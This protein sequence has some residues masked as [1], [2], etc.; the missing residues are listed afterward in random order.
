MQLYNS[1]DYVVIVTSTESLKK[2]QNL[3]LNSNK[4]LVACIVPGIEIGQFQGHDSYDFYS[5]DEQQDFSQEYISQHAV[6]FV[7]EIIDPV[8]RTISL[9]KKTKKHILS[10]KNMYA[11][12]AHILVALII[13]LEHLAQ[14]NP[15]SEFIFFGL[16]IPFEFPER[17][18]IRKLFY[19]DDF[20][21]PI[22]FSFFKGRNIRY[23]SIQVRPWILVKFLMVFRS[24]LLTIYKFLVISIRWLKEYSLF[25]SKIK[26]SQNV[27][28]LRGASE[29]WSIKP[30]LKIFDKNNRPYTIVQDDLL[31]NPSCKKALVEENL[32][33]F[34]I[35]K[36][37]SF[38]GLCRSFLLG[39]KIAKK[40][41]SHMLNSTS[42]VLI[43]K[44]Q[45]PRIVA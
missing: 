1:Y 14:K 33:F 8:V 27:I 40:V 28:I 30:I 7:N 36:F 16:D 6:N 19:M 5:I 2:V 43:S 31:N 45:M 29:V 15:D 25:N 24:S 26:P 10:L 17:I 44:T 39:L 38:Y 35:H 13:Y 21:S 3:Q 4:I 42:D 22:L 23:R 9:D 41:K 32:D 12:Y 11:F 34:N 20:L 37:I 18:E